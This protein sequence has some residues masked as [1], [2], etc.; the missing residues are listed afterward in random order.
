MAK[1]KEVRITIVLECTECPQQALQARLGI[2]RYT[3]QKNRRNT[4]GKL[5][6]NKFCRY[7]LK[8]TSHKEI[9]K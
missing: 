2:S 5:E 7:C 8:H 4:P 9:K 1:N 6:L 3:T